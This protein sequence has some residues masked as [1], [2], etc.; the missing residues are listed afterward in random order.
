LPRFYYLKLNLGNELNFLFLDKWFFKTFLK[1]F[2]FFYKVFFKFYFFRIKLKGLGY[3][4][5]KMTNKLYRF[6]VAYNHYIF[7]YVS[8]NVFVWTKK[9]NLLALSIDKVKLNN[10]F[11]QLLMLKKI[12][13]YEKSNSFI[14]PK[15]ILFIK[16]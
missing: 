4:I 7:F 16:K 15:K 8:S 11:Y 14:V 6:F 3:R 12:D 13:F 10:I 1:Q 5:R 2:F 9:R